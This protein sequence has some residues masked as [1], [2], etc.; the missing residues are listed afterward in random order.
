[1]VVIIINKH[2]NVM[3]LLS[4]EVNGVMSALRKNNALQIMFFHCIHL[5]CI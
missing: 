5:L 3:P 4:L 2:R 1:M